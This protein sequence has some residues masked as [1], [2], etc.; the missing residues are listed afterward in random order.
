MS[1]TFK[2]LRLTV[3]VIAMAGC[4]SKPKE[5]PAGPN[6]MLPDRSVIDVAAVE[7]AADQ[8]G[9]RNVLPSRDESV[10]ALIRKSEEYARDINQSNPSAKP[11]EPLPV[12]N[13]QITVKP[14][15][16]TSQ[17]M[18][19][20]QQTQPTVSNETKTVDI[21]KQPT[22]RAPDA[23]A[24]TAAPMTAA[25]ANIAEPPSIAK[26]I[27][28]PPVT[29]AFS[30]DVLEK[31][32]LSRVKEYP[33]DVAGHLEYQLMQFLKDQPTPDLAT[34]SA[35]P[36]EDRELIAAVMDGLS[37]FRSQLRADNNMLLSKKIRPMVDLSARLQSQAELNIPSLTLCTKVDGF[38]RYDPIDPPRFIAS[39]DTQVIVYCEVA[40][41]TSRISGEKNL[42]QT[43]L[44]QDI[45]L[46]SEAG[47]PVWTDPTSRVQDTSRVRRHDFFVRKL[48]TLPAS[49]PVGRYLLKVTVTDQQASRVAEASLPLQIVV[50]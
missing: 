43:D 45:V 18:P 42:W 28:Q 36:E 1:R 7:P 25:N 41:F 31:K 12:I 22:L 32:L 6:A 40:N 30:S 34:L 39:R 10:A 8:T 16:Q 19:Q 2:S 50:Q 5:K 38:G 24:N 29:P 13:Q 35:L 49:L 15:E 44:T 20:N 27:T 4:A 21:S 11:P 17:Q 46:Y 9:A 14:P 3:F 26:I 48:V 23:D 33:R 47:Q 37:N